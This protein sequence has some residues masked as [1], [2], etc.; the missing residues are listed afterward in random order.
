MNIIFTDIDGVLNSILHNRWSKNAIN[1]Y[2]LVCYEYN[3]K[4]VITSTWRTNHT[5][6]E[7]QKIFTDNGIDVEIYDYT[8][9]LH[10][11]RGLEIKEWLNNNKVDNYVVVDDRI[12]DIYPH[13]NN[14]KI[15]E[16]RGW[17][18]LTVD[19]YNSIV[20]IFK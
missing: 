12:Y 17:E 14:S 4:P 16:C 20:G 10:D 15:V 18:G 13:I 7:L 2:N 6:E 19:E 8:P 9:I 1:I 11:D 3:L 5:K